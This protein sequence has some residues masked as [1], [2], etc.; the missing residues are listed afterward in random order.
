MGYHGVPQF[1]IFIYKAIH[2]EY[3]NVK[4]TD[5]VVDRYCMVGANILYQRN[6]A[7]NHLDEETNGQSR[8]LHWLSSVLNGTYGARFPT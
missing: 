5:L 4:D 7:G 8:A 1:P 3:S 2:D 6:E